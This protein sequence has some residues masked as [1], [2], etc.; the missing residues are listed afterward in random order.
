VE[1]GRQRDQI[2]KNSLKIITGSQKAVIRSWVAAFL[3]LKTLV[4]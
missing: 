4:T 2:L 1:T 3:Q